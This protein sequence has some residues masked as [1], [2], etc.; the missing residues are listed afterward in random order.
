[1]NGKQQL[2]LIAALLAL[3]LST[4]SFAQAQGVYL[5]GSIGQAQARSWCDTEPG[6]TVAACDDKDTGWKVFLGY[7]FHRNFAAE[8]SFMNAG[9]YSATVNFFGTPA[10]VSTDATAFGLAALG[11]LP[12]SEQ[13]ELFGKLGFVNGESDAE[14]VV[15]GSRVAVGDRG[16]ELTFGLG[17]VYNVAP[18]FGIRAE[19]ENI[20]DADISMLS[21]GIQYRF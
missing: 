3:G 9:E 5:G 2:V 6:I 1:M 15:G 7:R 14:V 8:A 19:W 17:A 10:S 11:I 12:V 16:T 20:D 18:R 21:V 13:L 4:A